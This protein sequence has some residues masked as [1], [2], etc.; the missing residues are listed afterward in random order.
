MDDTEFVPV[1]EEVTLLWSRV[2]EALAANEY[3]SPRRIDRLASAAGLELAG[4]TI[5]GWFETW[6]VVPAWEKFQVLINALAAEHDEDWRSLHRAALTADRE[7]KRKQRQRKDLGRATTPVP[8]DPLAT[9][10][11]LG[12][13]SSMRD[14]AR[15]MSWFG[16]G[17][18]GQSPAGLSRVSGSVPRQLPVD[19]THFTGRVAE[20]RTLDALLAQNDV[21]RHAATVIAVITGT[22]GVGKTALAVRWAYRVRDRFPE[23]QLFVNLRGYDPGSPMTPEQALEEFLRALD[24]PADRIPAELGARAALYRS[25]LDGRRILVVLDNASR[26]G[27]CC[28]AHP[29]VGSW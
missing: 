16:A 15:E 22:A 13:Q 24:V 9:D 1:P 12:P 28:L 27:H 17:P 4:S 8:F 3:P 18:A 7:H 25:L 10:G 2:Q 26:Y 14:P 23:G 29:P 20:M 21:G 5:A 19:V 6:S 11:V